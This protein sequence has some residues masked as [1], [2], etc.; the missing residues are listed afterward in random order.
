LPEAE[1]EEA[2]G[3]PIHKLIVFHIVE[4]KLGRVVEL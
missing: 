3:R 4:E 1:I 2:V